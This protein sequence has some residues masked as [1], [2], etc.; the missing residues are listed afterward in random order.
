MKKLLPALTLLLPIALLAQKKVDL[1]P[2]YFTAQY[3]SLPKLRLDSTY[4]TYNVEVE[5]TRL[6]QNFLKEID[7]EK[8]VILDGWRKLS[9]DGHLTIKIKLEDLLPE[10]VTVN[11]RIQNIKDKAGNITSTKIFYRQE[12]TYTFAATAA[13]TD[14]KGTHIMD[15]A[16]ADRGYKQVYKSP[17]FA[18]KK[19]AEGYF[20]VNALTITND[21][22]RSCVN[23]AMHYLSERIT[24]SFGFG[25]VTVRDKMWII[26]SRKH[27]EYSAHRQAFQRLNEVLFSMNASNS[28]DGVREQLQPVIQY[29]EGIKKKYTSTKKHDRKIRY[30]SYFN[31]A[32]LYY[33]LDDP[34]SMMREANG[35]VLND[36]DTRDGKAF[37]N[38]ASNLKSIFQQANIYTRH[39]S[40]DPAK[41]RGPYEN[42][43]EILK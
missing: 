17:E 31:L 21:L 4:R 35:L 14:Y 30:A 40:I 42:N 11:E 36:F 27:P 12:V 29:F 1:D 15:Q 6:M 20:L 28:I 10:S 33:Y 39:F 7:P 3:R 2:Y 18:F 13:I 16:L 9:N 22:Y 32:V 43:A 19:M 34:Q 5:G 24:S 25:D 23:R 37:E 8:T 38:S 26:D 41:F